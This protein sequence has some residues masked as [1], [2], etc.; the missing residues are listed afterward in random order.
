MH[1]PSPLLY[2]FSTMELHNYGEGGQEGACIKTVLMLFII[3]NF[4]AV[5][6][7]PKRPS[8]RSRGRDCCGIPKLLI[9]AATAWPGPSI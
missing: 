5:V 9:R 4:V 1:M 7:P 6:F 2:N 8:Q 3:D